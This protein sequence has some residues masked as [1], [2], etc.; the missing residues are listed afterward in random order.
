MSV[1]LDRPE[2]ADVSAVHLLT[3]PRVLLHVLHGGRITSNVNSW[4]TS[5]ESKAVL[6]SLWD[7]LA[8]FWSTQLKTRELKCTKREWFM[9]RVRE[10]VE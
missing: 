4:L 6:T 3:R 5:T 2:D 9:T 1:L 7:V 10:T 8:M